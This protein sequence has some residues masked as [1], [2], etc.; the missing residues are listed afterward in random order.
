MKKL[1]FLLVGFAFLAVFGCKEPKSH[2]ITIRSIPVSGINL[3]GQGFCKEGDNIT[4]QAVLREGYH[5]DYS[6]KGW[7]KIGGEEI[8]STEQSYTFSATEDM[9]LVATFIAPAG[10][11]LVALKSSPSGVAVLTGAKEY[12]QGS[13]AT[14][15]AILLADYAD[16]IFDGWYDADGTLVSTDNPYSFSVFTATSLIAKFIVPADTKHNLKEGN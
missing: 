10:Y 4:V 5:K 7:S 15:R 1:F 8:L 14:V 11:A 12:V 6:F 16:Y 3:H 9:S 2:F 13:I